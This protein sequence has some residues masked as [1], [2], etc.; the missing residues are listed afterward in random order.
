MKNTSEDTTL[1]RAELNA[2]LL[3][4]PL[5]HETKLNIIKEALETNTYY[6]NSDRI[7]EGLLEYAEKPSKIK[8]TEFA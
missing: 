8:E 2:R 1:D 4:T 3:N 5:A 6:I 7:A